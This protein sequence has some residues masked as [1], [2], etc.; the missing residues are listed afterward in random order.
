MSM[1]GRGY[2]VQGWR[3]RY[4]RALP[5][6]HRKECGVKVIHAGAWQADACI[7]RSVEQQSICE[8]GKWKRYWLKRR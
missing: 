7:A 5:K 4:M 1:A 8:H 2:S 3:Q 6:K